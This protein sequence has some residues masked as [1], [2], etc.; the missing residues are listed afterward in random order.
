MFFDH[1]RRISF[2]LLQILTL[3]RINGVPSYNELRKKF[4]P[5]GDLYS[6]SECNAA[7]AQDSIDCFKLITSNLTIA[8]NLQ[9]IYGK[10]SKIDAIVGMFAEEKSPTVPLPPT[11]TTILR[12]E[13]E[14]KR[15]TDRFWYEGDTYTQAEQN[16]IKKVTMKEIIERNTNVFDVQV[17][18]FKD[19]GPNDT[20]GE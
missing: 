18:P 17:N 9:T 19:P 10:V 13:F 1:S 16:D 12:L 4:H 15:Q 6:F 5:A 8:Q 2:L 7:A 11:I 3:G 20:L 14:K